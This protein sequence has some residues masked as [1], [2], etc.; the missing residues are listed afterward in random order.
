MRENNLG[1]RGLEVLSLGLAANQSLTEIDL[2]N[3]DWCPEIDVRSKTLT[4][5][6]PTE[7]GDTVF[8]VGEKTGGIG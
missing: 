3:N 4:R 2:G 1:P 6:T 8:A 7:G 5:S